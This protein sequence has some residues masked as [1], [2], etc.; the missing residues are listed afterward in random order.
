M[1]LEEGIREDFVAADIDAIDEV[2]GFGCV[3]IVFC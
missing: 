2:G 3:V 1:D